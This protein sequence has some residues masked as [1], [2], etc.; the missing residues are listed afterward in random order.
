VEAEPASVVPLEPVFVGRQ[1]PAR[2]PKGDGQTAKIVSILLTVLAVVV[3]ITLKG[4][5]LYLRHSKSD[6]DDYVFVAEKV[7]DPPPQ[8][9]RPFPRPNPKPNDPV[10]V[11]PPPRREPAPPMPG[12]PV[13]P[14]PPPPQE[15]PKP[16]QPPG[17]GK[18]ADV[19]IGRWS[20][21]GEYILQFQAGGQGEQ[22]VFS[23]L[24]PMT[25]QVE[26]EITIAMGPAAAGG[27]E[28]RRFRILFQTRDEF[29]LADGRPPYGNARRYRRMGPSTFGGFE[30]R[31]TIATAGGGIGPT[32]LAASPD[33]NRVAAVV[34]KSIRVYDLAT[35]K[36]LAS[37]IGHQANVHSIAFLPG[38]RLA[39]GA[40]DHTVRVWNITTS[41]QQTMLGGQ[42]AVNSI[43]VTPNGQFLAS[44]GFSNQVKLIQ[45]VGGKELNQLTLEGNATVNAVAI[46]PDGKW[47]AGG[48]NTQFVKLW[49]LPVA[50]EKHELR[51]GEERLFA[52]AFSPDSTTLATA[53]GEV[54]LW[55]VASG[56]QKSGFKVYRHQVRCLA[57]SPDGKTLAVPCGKWVQLYDTAADQ[58][59]GLLISP[60]QEIWSVAWAQDGRMLLTGSP[61][62]IHVWE[63][64]GE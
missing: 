48:G 41:K 38:D 27:G 11:R 53:G 57:F 33:G 3:G 7:P 16:E 58:E 50:A 29:T 35:G 37:L 42:G 25:Y 34:G 36:E 44:G 31:R 30:E 56:K 17:L 64:T 10:A 1:R 6:N 63:Q 28:P 61:D 49:E 13:R 51:L 55:D 26:D 15:E 59:T 62:G 8:A 21:D 40:H 5:S 20:R 12:A 46:S 24:A 18:L 2:P 9:D 39:S 45:L 54:K 60:Q 52:L 4:V 32:V 14:E 23:R 22:A 43:A 47:L 19:V